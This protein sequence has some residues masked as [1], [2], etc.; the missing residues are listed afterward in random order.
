MSVSADLPDIAGYRILGELGRG[1]MATVYLA[2]QL[3]LQ[4][5]V[6]LKV[7]RPGAQ[8]DGDFERFLARFLRE[9]R[10]LARLSRHENL[11]GVYDVGRAGG[12]AYM[13]VEYVAGGT[14]ADR[15]RM[16]LA[17]EL[18]WAVFR[19]VLEAIAVVHA[20]GIVHR[21]LKPGNVLMRG[22]TPVLTDFGIARDVHL[23]PG[24]TT[25]NLIIGT[26]LYMAPEQ[27]QAQPIDA[28][29]DLYALGAL[30]HELLVG[31]PP[32]VADSPMAVCM[33]HLSAEVPRLPAAWAGLQPLLDALLAKDRERR[34]RNVAQVD[35]MIEALLLADPALA[36]RL[37]AVLATAAAPA[38]VV[39]AA[40]APPRVSTVGPEALPVPHPRRRGRAL[41]MTLGALLLAALAWWWRGPPWPESPVSAPVETIAAT[42]VPGVLV[43]DA[44]PW[45]RVLAVRSADG[46]D[47][48]GGAAEATPLLLELPAGAYRVEISDAEGE[49]HRQ[50]D[51][52]IPAGGT[53]TLQ[54]DFG[55][56]A[57]ADDYLRAAGYR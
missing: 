42:P 5:Q 13:A 41:A 24:H 10:L 15:L 57:S 31:Q 3:S 29:A 38:P 16:G 47:W 36:Q 55:S 21:D 22:D 49:L 53:A 46:R 14:L 37:G 30:L 35:A 1:G 45:G 52:A 9:G 17:P 48:L 12:M 19:Q 28:R 4:R 27:I 50:L 44:R 20:V 33:L 39:R 11:C 7:L 56:A 8:G 2:E 18:A 40:R 43:I 51:A 23:G 34:P 54:T 26:P 32:Y 25:A 6:A